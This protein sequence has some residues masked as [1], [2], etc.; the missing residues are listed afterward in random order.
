[1]YNLVLSWGPAATRLGHVISDCTG[2]TQGNNQGLREMRSGGF[3]V[4]T[5]EEI[6]ISIKRK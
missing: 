5:K 6:R 2:A 1:M 3:Q 4:P